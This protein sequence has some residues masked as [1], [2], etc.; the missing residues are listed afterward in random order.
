MLER[1]GDQVFSLPHQRGQHLLSAALRSQR[2]GR[3]S[4]RTKKPPIVEAVVDHRNVAPT[5]QLVQIILGYLHLMKNRVN[6]WLSEAPILKHKDFT[7]PGVDVEVVA[8]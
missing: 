5:V 3:L 2:T 1:F 4:L 7:G 8:R 6:A